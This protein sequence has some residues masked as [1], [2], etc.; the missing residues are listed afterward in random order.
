[1]LADLLLPLDKDWVPMQRILDAYAELATT[2]HF[3]SEQPKP[4]LVAIL[5]FCTLSWIKVISDFPYVI[6][7][8]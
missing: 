5:N 8:N 1:M 7:V 4:V 6:T 3:A 2:L